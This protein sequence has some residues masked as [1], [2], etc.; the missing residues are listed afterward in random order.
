MFAIFPN[1]TT[2]ETE[3]IMSDIRAKIKAKL[4]E[5]GLDKLTHARLGLP[6][7]ETLDITYGVAEGKPGKYGIPGIRSGC[8]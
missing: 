2:Q 3:E 7:T 5:L 8:G 4:P 1:Y 6:N